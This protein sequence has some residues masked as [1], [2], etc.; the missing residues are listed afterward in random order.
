MTVSNMSVNKNVH[1][2][3]FTHT[4]D[5]LDRWISIFFARC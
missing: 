4:T 5:H 3:T 1:P 2:K